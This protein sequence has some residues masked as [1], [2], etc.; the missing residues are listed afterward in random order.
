M[1]PNNLMQDF[2]DGMV[3]NQKSIAEEE[4]GLYPSISHTSTHAATLSLLPLLQVISSVATDSLA[5]RA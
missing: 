3:T 1:D 4:D 5:N 2:G